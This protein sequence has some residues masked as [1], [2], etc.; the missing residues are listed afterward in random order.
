VA[1]FFPF[2]TT[3][4]LNGHSFIEQELNRANIA[5]RTNDNAFLAV[6]N[7]FLEWVNNKLAKAEALAIC[8]KGGATWAVFAGEGFKPPPSEEYVRE[9]IEP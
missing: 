9:R 4:Y 7:V 2:Q 6:D 8:E 3:Y 1:T 5:F